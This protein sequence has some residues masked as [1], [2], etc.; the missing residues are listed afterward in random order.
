M[1]VIRIDGRIA[2]GEHISLTSAVSPQRAFRLLV[3]EARRPSRMV[4]SQGMPLGLFRGTRTFGLEPRDGGTWFTM[5]E[6]FTGPLAGL[7]ARSVPDLQPSFEQY[8][9]G[10]AAATASPTGPD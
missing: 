10:L 1:A 3:A 9:D 2:Q 5:T 8:A 6:E 4:W 7:V